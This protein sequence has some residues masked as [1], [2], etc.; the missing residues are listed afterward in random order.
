LSAHVGASIRDHG[1]QLLNV[2]PLRT[3]PR[4]PDLVCASAEA[5]ALARQAATE[6]A[7]PGHVGDYLGAEAEAERVVTHLF[8]C[9][10]P[11]YRGWR[12]AVTVARAA[13]SKTVTV[14]E[15]VLL[16]GPEAVLAPPWVPWRERVRPGDVG[17]GDILPA[18]ADDERLVPVASLEGE[19]G[20]ADWGEAGWAAAGLAPPEVPVTDGGQD[21]GAAGGEP[22]DGAAAAEGAGGRGAE[23]A[24]STAAEGADST[25]AER[26]AV[27][28][29]SAAPGVAALP[30]AADGRPA[31]GR[32][33]PPGGKRGSRRPAAGEPVPGWDTEP[34]RARVLS[35]IGRDEAAIRWYTSEHG[36]QS[37]LASAAPGPCLSCGF[38]VRLAG[39][40]GRVF[41]VCANEFA[42]DDGRVVSVDHGC[43]AHSEGP[44]PPGAESPL[45][46][47]TGEFGYDMVD[48]PGVTVEETEFEPID[49]S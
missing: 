25:A 9:L 39:P 13:R 3:R 14:S 44:L 19:D 46:P 22:A 34:H 31:P 36:P 32:T 29:G 21:A 18:A 28:G 4:E 27:T 10:D 8:A 47:V 30:G 6:L 33:A 49:Q 41:G 2:S 5:R 7:G 24:D 23:G 45:P 12:W 26:P 17:V 48:V 15:C 35:A 11:A 16:P 40:L 37:P 43:G 38:F 1:E 20:L 42:P